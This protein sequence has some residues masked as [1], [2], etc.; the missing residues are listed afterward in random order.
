[1][2]LALFIVT[3]FF[4]LSPFA[5]SNLDKIKELELEAVTQLHEARQFKTI[6]EQHEYNQAFEETLRKMMAYDE[7][8]T[9]DFDTLATL[10]STI[11]SPDGS[12]RIFNWNME[13]G[14]YKEHKYYCLVMK[15][16]PKSGDF[17][18]IELFDHSDD[19][20]YDAEFKAL[21]DKKWYGCLYYKIIPV[22]KGWRTQYTLLGWDGN[23]MVSNKKIIETMRFHKK[24][25]LKFGEAMFREDGEKTKRRVIFTYTED[26]VMSLK[27]QKTKK[28]EMIIFDHLSSIVPGAEE[29]DIWM[30]PDLSFDAYILENGKWNYI[31]DV[32][33]RTRKKFNSKY[34]APDN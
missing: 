27:H 29:I 25:N 15:K 4:T 33:A 3:L 10:I 13:Y 19:Y 23:D 17:I 9:H 2:K 8:F 21:T 30:G 28:E 16:D 6:K 7:T 11:K 5:Q 34:N 31:K 14:D 26:A 22:D 1:M 18:I 12:F 32:D 20:K 24:D